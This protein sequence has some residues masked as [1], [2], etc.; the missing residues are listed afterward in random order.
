MFYECKNPILDIVS[1][2]H[3]KWQGGNFDIKPRPHCALAFRIK[4]NATITAGGKEYYINANDILYLPQN[5]PYKAKYTDTEMIVFHFV[6]QIDDPAPE[7]WS[8]SD[9][10]QIYKAFLNAEALWKNKG[11]GYTA[12]ALSQMYFIL[13][14]ICEKETAVNLPKGFLDAV[15]YINLN[16][17]SADISIDKICK[18]AGIS[19]TN[20][21][22]LFGKNYKKTPSEYI[23]D[24]RLERARNLIACGISVE[25]AALDSGFN[26][27]K[28]F[29]RVVKNHFGCTPRELKTYG[30]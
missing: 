14:K 30:K 24:L 20:L 2:A 22:L 3:M 1:V 15:S 11:S 28:Y 25:N 18:N 21:R 27:P 5:I 23:T 26:D 16:F 6:T 4:G 7:V 12:H 10:T 9:P 29:A 13:G 19:A 17:T 8:V